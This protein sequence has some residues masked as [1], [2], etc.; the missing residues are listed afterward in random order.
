MCYLLMEE[1]ISFAVSFHQTR[2]EEPEYFI[3][4]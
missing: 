4:F 3:E 2:V 1:N